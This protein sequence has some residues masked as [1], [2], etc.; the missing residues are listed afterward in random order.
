MTATRGPEIEKYARQK[1]IGGLSRDV[2][3]TVTVR[4]DEIEQRLAAQELPNTDPLDVALAH[5]LVE[6]G[7]TDPEALCRVFDAQ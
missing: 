2:I 7:M 3:A 1:K 4:L 6:G 5:H